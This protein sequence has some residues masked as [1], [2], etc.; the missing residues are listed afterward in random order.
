MKISSVSDGD[1]DILTIECRSSLIYSE[2]DRHIV[3]H[4]FV[5][6]SEAN[7]HSGFT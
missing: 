7:I 1:I 2:T 6:A 4:E 3:C 5:K